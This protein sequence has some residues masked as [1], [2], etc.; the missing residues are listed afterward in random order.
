M[1]GRLLV[2]RRRLDVHLTQI[3]RGVSGREG[4]FHAFLSY[5]GLP[6]DGRATG[7]G[8]IMSQDAGD[9]CGPASAAALITRQAAVAPMTRR[10]AC[11]VSRGR[12]RDHH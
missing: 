8:G 6:T 1:A 5:F 3:G 2:G 10:A 12:G 9:V 4:A 7:T 11:A